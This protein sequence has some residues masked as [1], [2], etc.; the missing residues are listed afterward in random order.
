MKLNSSVDMHDK[1]CIN[2]KGLF[3]RNVLASHTVYEVKIEHKYI[4]NYYNFRCP[5]CNVLLSYTDNNVFWLKNKEKSFKGWKKTDKVFKF[6][7][8]V[9]MYNPLYKDKNVIDGLF[10]QVKG[11]SIYFIP[12]FMLNYINSYG[13]NTDMVYIVP[14]RLFVDVIGTIYPSLLVELNLLNFNLPIYSFY[15]NFNDKFNN[16][17][18]SS[19]YESLK[20][21]AKI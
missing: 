20:Q 14:E 6:D 13:I 3:Q 12:E 11:K 9:Y 8:I 19:D 21:K 10:N 5:Y 7:N 18:E 15:Y 17:Y 4:V 1:H 2:C 16:L